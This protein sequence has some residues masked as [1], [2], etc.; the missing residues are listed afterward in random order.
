V[1]ELRQITIIGLGLLGGSVA[2]S[3]RRL[4]QA[5]R[6]VGF[7]HRAGTRAKAARLLAGADIVSDLSCS[8]VGSD[9]V[10]LATPIYTFVKIFVEIRDSL[11]DG[12][13]VTD[14]GS[15]KILP[16]RWAAK[17]LPKSVY[18]VGSHPIAGSEQRGVEF[19]RDDLFEQADC[20]LTA[21]KKT[22]RQAIEII[23]DFW[24]QIGCRV[25][26]MTPAEH[27]RIFARVSHLPHL[28][29]AALVNACGDKRLRFA[30]KG[31]MDTSRVASGPSNIWCD[32]L[33]ANA[34]NC[35][36]GIDR[37]KKELDEF[38]K[39]IKAGNSAKLEKLLEMARDRRA[40][41]IKD[42]LKKKEFI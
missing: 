36:K 12:A 1:K 24:S 35:T 25:K 17:R 21:T 31:F 5:I 8:V 11:E 40:R 37:L 3:A 7:T 32:I 30:G 2:L 29:A 28:T 13:I 6:V 23:K 41:L 4:G 34:G 42:K 39:A 33:L 18:Y 14:V 20:I 16:H 38:K 9:I 10:I 26:L 19:A 22:N 27:D 15:T